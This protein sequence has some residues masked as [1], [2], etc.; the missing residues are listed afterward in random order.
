MYVHVSRLRTPTSLTPGERFL[1]QAAYKDHC[2]SDNLRDIAEGP[3]LTDSLDYRRR[4]VDVVTPTVADGPSLSP[5][6]VFE[7]LNVRREPPA[8]AP[9]YPEMGVEQTIRELCGAGEFYPPEAG[10]RETGAAT[11]SMAASTIR[12]ADRLPRT[13]R[14]SPCSPRRGSF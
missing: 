2:I 5:T 11:S 13:I 14:S 6:A 8:A 10:V 4:R 9:A 3:A 7:G 12:R 1:R